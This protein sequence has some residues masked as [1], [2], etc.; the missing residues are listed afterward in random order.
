MKK[1]FILT[2]SFVHTH[3]LPVTLTRTLDVNP[4]KNIKAGS[5]EASKRPRGKVL[6]SF[7]SVF[8]NDE[9]QNEINNNL[10]IRL[11]LK[12]YQREI[13]TEEVFIM[14]CFRSI[15]GLR[16]CWLSYMVSIKEVMND[17]WFNKFSNC[18]S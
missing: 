16:F 3:N 1:H 18:I 12:V 8:V 14:K 7:R 9:S 10:D 5:R 2:C 4:D 13:L 6:T 15:S 11:I 17:K